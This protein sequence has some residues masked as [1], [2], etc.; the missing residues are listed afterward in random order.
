MFLTLLDFANRFTVSIL[1]MFWWELVHHMTS[2][3]ILKWGPNSSIWSSLC[4]YVKDKIFNVLCPNWRA[5]WGW[6]T[7]SYV[8]VFPVTVLRVCCHWL[9]RLRW[10]IRDALHTHAP[11]W[12]ICRSTLN[13]SHTHSPVKKPP[14]WTVSHGRACVW[15]IKGYMPVFH[16]RTCVWRA[17]RMVHRTL[18]ISLVSG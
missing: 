15:R 9:P 2:H 3:S 7:S 14:L 17:S 5:Y 12:N 18:A 13:F 1:R 11:L 16:G 6:L 8:W 4:H 10:T